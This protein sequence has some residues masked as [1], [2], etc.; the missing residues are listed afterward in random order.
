MD[1]SLGGVAVAGSIGVVGIEED[2][3]FLLILY[4]SISLYGFL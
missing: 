4:K 1:I 3:S 2:I